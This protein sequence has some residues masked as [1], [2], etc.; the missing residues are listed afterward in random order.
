M[1]RCVP[2][3]ALLGAGLGTKTV[4]MRLMNDGHILLEHEAENTTG[5]AEA[6]VAPRA[7]KALLPAPESRPHPHGRLVSKA[8]G[9]EGGDHLGPPA[10][11]SPLVGAPVESWSFQQ[12]SS[13]EMQLEPVDTRPPEPL[14]EKP[15]SWSATLWNVYRT[16]YDTVAP[17][18]AGAGNVLATA[19]SLGMS[20]DSCILKLAYMFFSVEN[21]DDYPYMPQGCGSFVYDI[22]TFGGAF[23]WSVGL[24]PRLLLLAG[25]VV[26]LDSPPAR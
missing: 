1:A 3:L 21:E 25:L 2:L 15:A 16:A 6:K 13:M 23:Q 10:L 11:E 22:A 20:P 19:A 26:V 7:D 14:Q 9:S 4:H 24:V 18:R 5:L 8:V 12:M 17:L